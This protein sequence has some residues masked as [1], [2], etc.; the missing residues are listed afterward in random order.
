MNGQVREGNQRYVL[1]AKALI[2]IRRE[3]MPEIGEIKK[4]SEI[5][6]KG[7]SGC[8]RYIW[9]ACVDCSKEHWVMLNKGFPQHQRCSR[10]SYLNQRGHK[11][12]NWKGGKKKR[13]DGYISI[14]LYP[15][16]FFYPMRDSHYYVSEHRLIMARHLGRCLQKF[17]IVHHKNGIRDD[18][19]IENLELAGTLGEHIRE[20]STGYKGGYQRGLIDGRLKQIKELKHLVE[21]QAN[22]IRLLQGQLTIKSQLRGV[23]HDNKGMF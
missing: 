1:S 3:R 21:E 19:R 2:G 18:N 5:G 14:Y 13:K 6:R 9:Q 8:S 4:G 16:D 10:C 20:H 17:E 7:G 12:P 15:D 11:N 23:R 22:E